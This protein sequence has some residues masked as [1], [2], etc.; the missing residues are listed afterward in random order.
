MDGNYIIFTNA[1]VIRNHRLTNSIDK[2]WCAYLMGQWK[3]RKNSTINRYKHHNLD[4]EV[5][6]RGNE[7]KHVK[8]EIFSRNK[9]SI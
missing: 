9:S 2:D 6:S 4:D 7:F 1:T 8:S 3:I 5:K